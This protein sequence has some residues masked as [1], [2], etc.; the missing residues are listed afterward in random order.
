MQRDL[1][2]CMQE[3]RRCEG[4]S[5]LLARVRAEAYAIAGT[6]SDGWLGPKRREVVAGRGKRTDGE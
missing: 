1:V 2:V 6:F 4:T 5:A 3:I